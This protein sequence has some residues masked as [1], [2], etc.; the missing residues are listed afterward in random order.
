MAIVDLRMHTGFFRV[1]AVITP[2]F[3]AGCYLVSENPVGGVAATVYDDRLPGLWQVQDRP[4]YMLVTML[5][6]GR[7]CFRFLENNFGEDSEFFCGIATRVSSE[8]FL[9]VRRFASPGESASDSAYIPVHYRFEKDRLVI[10]V[11]NKEFFHKA[12]AEKKIRGI[13]PAN[14]GL[15]STAPTRLTGSGEEIGAFILSQLRAAGLFEP[16][17]VFVRVALPQGKNEGN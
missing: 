7:L 10:S 14:T 9:N 12:I 11:F 16:P 15:Y 2:L 8:S 3:F 5:K 6:D 17:L 4:G 1:L 13:L